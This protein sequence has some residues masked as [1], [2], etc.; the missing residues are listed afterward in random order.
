LNNCFKF[1]YSFDVGWIRFGWWFDPR[2]L[3]RRFENQIRICSI[4]RWRY[5]A[6]RRRCSND[7][8]GSWIKKRWRVNIW[9]GV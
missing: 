6:I 3:D 4:S 8:Y 1:K 9:R 7:G 2:C 5:S